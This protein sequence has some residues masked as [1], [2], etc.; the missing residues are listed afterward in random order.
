VELGY[1][2]LRTDYCAYI[3]RLDDDIS[4]LIVYIDDANAFAEKSTNDE[5]IRQLQKRYEITV[6]G[7]PTLLLGIHIERDRKN[8]TLTLSQNRY[9]WKILEKAGMGDCSLVSTPMDP[10]V[11]LCKT[12]GSDE[13]ENQTRT[14]DYAAFI[15]ELLYAAHATRPD[16]LYAITTLAQF[17]QKP[18]TEH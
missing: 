9:I 2:R 15:G 18:S 4:I 17:T 12:E 3:R 16:I 7:E 13:D 14:N 6:M 10:N 5:L 11:A 8:R 1:T